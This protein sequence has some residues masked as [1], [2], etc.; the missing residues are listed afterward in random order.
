M[1]YHTIG[2]FA[3]GR[4]ALGFSSGFA[5][6]VVNEEPGP[7]NIKAWRP[8]AGMDTACGIVRDCFSRT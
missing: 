8:V 5:L 3:M 1:G 7:H 2:R 4:R 6:K